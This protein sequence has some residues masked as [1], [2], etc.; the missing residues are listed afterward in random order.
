MAKKAPVKRGKSTTTKT[1]TTVHDAGGQLLLESEEWNPSTFVDPELVKSDIPLAYVSVQRNARNY[2][3]KQFGGHYDVQ[4]SVMVPCTTANAEDAIKAA[5][6]MALD[7][8]QPAASKVRKAYERAA[9][10]GKG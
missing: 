10:E 4:V 3:L 9:G 1:R 7:F 6:K 5:D 2:A 8:L